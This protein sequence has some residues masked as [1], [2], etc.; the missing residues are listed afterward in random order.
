MASFL[1]P[2]LGLLHPHAPADTKIRQRHRS[3]RKRQTNNPLVMQTQGQAPKGSRTYSARHSSRATSHIFQTQRF[4][5]RFPSHTTRPQGHGS[6]HRVSLHFPPPS[7]SSSTSLPSPHTL[8]GNDSTEEEQQPQP[9]S[10]CQAAPDIHWSKVW[11]N[12]KMKLLLI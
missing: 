5:R 8:C 7:S 6:H 4:F 3:K 1:V 11:Y 12:I 10:T 9:G 2:E